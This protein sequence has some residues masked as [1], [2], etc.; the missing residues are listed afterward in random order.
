MFQLRMNDKVVHESVDATLTIKEVS[1]EGV[2][3]CVWADGSKLMSG[4]FPA[5]ELTYAP[6]SIKALAVEAVRNGKVDEE[7]N[8]AA[9]SDAS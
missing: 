9:A 1:A 6:G 2:A 3:T 7:S 4:T 5:A 8:D